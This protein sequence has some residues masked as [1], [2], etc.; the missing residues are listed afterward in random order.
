[1]RQ[2]APYQPNGSTVEQ[3]CCEANG[4]ISFEKSVAESGEGFNADTATF[5]RGMSWTGT[6]CRFTWSKSK[7]EDGHTWY[8]RAYLVYTDTE[9]NVHTIYGDPVWQTYSSNGD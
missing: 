1:M 8:V 4:K 9:G 6:A 7:V 5:V 3:H 2:C